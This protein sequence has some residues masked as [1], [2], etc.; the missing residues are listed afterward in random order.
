MSKSK[1]LTALFPT[2][3]ATAQRLVPRRLY[4]RV[5]PSDIAQSTAEV[6]LKAKLSSISCLESWA[7]GVIRKL[8]A[9]TLSR[10]ASAIPL[11][12]E[13]HGLMESGLAGSGNNA[14]STPDPGDPFADLVD[15][16]R[17]DTLEKTILRKYFVEGETMRSIATATGLPLSTLHYRFNQALGRVRSVRDAGPGTP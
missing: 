16:A 17:L 6:L 1:A 13:I 9:K 3:H 12:P 8:I 10:Q 4:G 11:Q 2:L 14:V 15:A 5:R 7:R